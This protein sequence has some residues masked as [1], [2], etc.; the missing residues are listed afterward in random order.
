VH[1]FQNQVARSTFG[2]TIKSGTKAAENIIPM[3]PLFGSKELL[4]STEK[5]K[6]KMEKLFKQIRV[7][8]SVEK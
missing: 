8:K 2:P 7:K 5:N 1:N 4:R 6:K 3:K